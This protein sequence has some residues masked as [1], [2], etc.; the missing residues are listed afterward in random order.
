MKGFQTHTAEDRERYALEDE[1]FGGI[2]NK[3]HGAIPAG[4]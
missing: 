1:K 2:E 4:G 3:E